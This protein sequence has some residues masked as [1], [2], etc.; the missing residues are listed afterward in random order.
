MTPQKYQQNRYT[1]KIF[2]FLKPPPPQK[3]TEIL[4]FEPPKNTRAYVC[5][6]ISEYHPL[7]DSLQNYDTKYHYLFSS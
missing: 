1:P 4:N 6:E 3:K 5:M 7:G 2:I